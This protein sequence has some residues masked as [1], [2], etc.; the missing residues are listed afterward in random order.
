MRVAFASTDLN[1]GCKSPAELEITLRISAIAAC[2]CSD[3]SSSR[4][5]A[6]SFSAKP[7][8]DA[9]LR[10]ARTFALVGRNASGRPV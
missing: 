4:V 7:G 8:R 3:S 10:H 9:S 2:C 6:A 1:T 5:L